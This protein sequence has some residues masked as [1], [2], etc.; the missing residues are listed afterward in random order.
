MNAE[1]FEIAVP[2][3]IVDDMTRRLR[4]VRWPGDFGNSQW[5]YGVEEGW[6]RGMAEYWANEFDWRAQEREMNRF[7]HFKSV[8]DGVPIHF[9]H[10]KSG[11][12]GAIP[13]I[14]SHGWPWT[15]W[16][17]RMLIEPLAEGDGD[18]PAFDVVVPSLP[19]VAFSSPLRTTGI[20]VRAIGRLWVKLMTEVLGYD[21]FAAGG[22]DF[23]A[24]IT[25]ELGH[26]HPD[27][28]IAVHLSLAIFPPEAFHLTLGPEAFAADEQWMYERNRQAAMSTVSHVAVHG[29]D[30][31]TLAYALADSPIGTAAWIWERRRAWSACD[32]DL[33]EYEGRDALCT[34]ASLYWLTNTVGT[35][36]RIYK[37]QFHGGPAGFAMNWP[38]LTPGKP[39]ITV[40]TG[41]T[42][43]PRDVV[44]L[45]RSIMAENTNLHHYRVL[46]KGGHFMP[47]ET[48]GELIEEYRAF[49]HKLSGE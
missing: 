45:P 17:W 33:A 40:P 48:P 46:E 10:L 44:H 34:T 7:P 28:L 43:A 2:D 4:D 29:N 21:R 13:I 25:A 5:R 19:G 30:P 1:P 41:V 8:I 22:G 35:A 20:N 32:G 26:A 27:K 3:E 42:I 12:P 38:L 37:E 6:L 39:V 49:F 36:M 31:Q 16:D 15:F 23:G 18:G 14:L 47:A 9:I 24:F 11:R